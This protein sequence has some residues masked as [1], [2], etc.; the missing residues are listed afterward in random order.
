MPWVGF[1]SI[2]AIMPKQREHKHE[3]NNLLIT[4]FF[5]NLNGFSNESKIFF[6]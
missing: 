3:I 6:F 1:G 2:H 4:F 5:F